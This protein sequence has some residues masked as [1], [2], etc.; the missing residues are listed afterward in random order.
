MPIDQLLFALALVYAAGRVGAE[1]AERLRQP[2]VVGEILA[3]VLIGPAAFALVPHGDQPVAGVLEAMSELGVIFLLFMVGLETD[4]RE[5]RRVGGMASS[6]AIV[7]IVVPLGLGFGLMLLLGDSTISAAFVGTAMVATS[8]GVTARVLRDRRKLSTREARIILGAA[9]V[10]DVLALLLLAVV[11]GVAAGTL[12]WTGIAIL[13][14]EALGFLVV[15]GT[16]GRRAARRFL[17]QVGKLKITEPAL[18][19][20]IAAA[21][22][23]AA[24]AS[25]IGLGA[26]I[27]AFLAGVIMGDPNEPDLEA[28]FLPLSTF[29]VPFFFVYVG[30][31]VD[32]DV[33]TSLGG[34]AL[35]LGITA[36]AIVGKLVGGLPVTRL[37]R[38]SAA[39][40]GVGMVPRGEVGII[41]ASL[42]LSLGVIQHELYSIVVLMSILTTLVAPPALQ[43]LFSKS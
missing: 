23:L 16:I 3:G 39:I 13:V 22:I 40:V 24:L 4:M 5:L 35:A 21:L 41:V 32:I 9:V 6:V 37:G 42:G 7:G 25:K 10:D 18:G 36:L 28:K 15:F 43:A 20:A 2:S 19:I 11:S 8:V 34:I 38:R 31:L 26:I 29:F 27:G 33:F 1:A 17:P 30:T 14:L 12:S